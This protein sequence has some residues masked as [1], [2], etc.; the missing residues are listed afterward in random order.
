[1]TTNQN[2]TAYAGWIA[3]KADGGIDFNGFRMGYESNG[4]ITF[5]G[6][7]FSQEG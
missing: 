3:R 2:L 1:M 6:P 4:T 7:A 5:V